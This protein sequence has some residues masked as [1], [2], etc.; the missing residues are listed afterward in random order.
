M[1]R[2]PTH[3]H[4]RVTLRAIIRDRKGRIIKVL[5]AIPAN[6]LINGFIKSL[7]ALFSQQVNIIVDTAGTNRTTAATQYHL[8]AAANAAVT[9]YG[10]VVGTGSDAVT[11]ADYK[12]A[13]QV[14]TNLAH[15]IMSFALTYPTAALGIL[16][17]SRTFTNNTGGTVQIR[18]V[19]LYTGILSHNYPACS[20]RSLY[21]V[22]LANG[23]AVTFTY[24][25]SFSL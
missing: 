6:S 8:D 10:M 24:S 23:L 14:V 5:P 3:K 18:E 20:D 25:F 1:S 21:S 15:S 7:Y 13:A 17:L 9:N 16:A 11:M 2:S 19:G 22:D 12:L 4:F